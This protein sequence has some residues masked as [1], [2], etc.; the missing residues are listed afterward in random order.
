MQNGGRKMADEETSVKEGEGKTL[1]HEEWLAS[2]RQRLREGHTYTPPPQSEGTST[3]PGAADQALTGLGLGAAA[4]AGVLG[5]HP[6][7]ITFQGIRSRVIVNALQSEVSDDDTRVHVGRDGDSTIVT[8]SQSQTSDPYDFSPAL[9]VTL[10]EAKDAL[11]VTLSELRKSTVR[12]KLSSIGGT[13]L[14]Q[15]RDVLAARRRRGVGGL[16][17]LAGNVREGIED[18]VDDI[19]DLTLPRRTWAV[20]DRVGGAAEEAYLE[21]VRKARAAEWQREAAVRAYTH[22]DWCGRAYGPDEATAVECPSCGGPRG[23]KPSSLE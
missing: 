8:I 4:A 3:G 10:L 22:C 2:E 20:I 7:P 16:L 17:D 6:N 18:L 19:E 1:S 12:R 13:V 23:A 5:P 9:T 21:A 15:G 14:E 11:T